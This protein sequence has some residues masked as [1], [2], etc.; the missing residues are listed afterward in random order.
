MP[1]EETTPILPN[2]TEPDK[3]PGL[4]KLAI[5]TALFGIYPW[6]PNIDLF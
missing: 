4:G 1:V 6:Y 2:R 5:T 3:P